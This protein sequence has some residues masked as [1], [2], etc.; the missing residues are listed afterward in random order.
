MPPQ[1]LFSLLEEDNIQID[2]SSAIIKNLRQLLL[3]RHEYD[4]KDASLLG[5]YSRK[6]CNKDIRSYVNILHSVRKKT[7]IK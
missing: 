6:A 4:W 2:V 1:D 5:A 3:L 7:Q